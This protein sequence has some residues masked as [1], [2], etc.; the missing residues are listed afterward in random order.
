MKSAECNNPNH[1]HNRKEKRMNMITKALSPA[2]L[3]ALSLALT[4]WAAEPP[5]AQ[6]QD[7]NDTTGPAHMS[8]AVPVP[9][10]VPVQPGEH[11]RLLF[12]KTDLPAIKARAQTPEGKKIVER[13]KATLGGGEAM[14]TV[15]NKAKRAYDENSPAPEGAF[16]ITHMAGFGMLYQLTGDKKYAE[17]GRQCFLKGKEGIRDRD[18][19]YSQT[20]VDGQLRLGPSLAM[21]ALG[22]DLCYDG[23]DEAFRQEVAQFIQ[24]YNMESRSAKDGPKPPVLSFKG[25][26]SDPRH[27]PLSNHQGAALGGAGFAVL[28]LLGDPGTDTALLKEMDAK[29]RERLVSSVPEGFGPYAFYA[30]GQGPSHVGVNSGL[31]PYVQALRVAAGQDYV[32]GSS[33]VQWFTLRWVMEVLGDGQGN[34]LYPARYELMGKSYGKERMLLGNGG[35]THGG[36]FSQGFGTIPE[37]YKPAL[38]WTYN[39]FAAAEDQNRF[40]T[41]N[42]PHRAIMA[43]VNWPIGMKAENPAGVMPKAICDTLH[44]YYVIRNRWQDSDDVVITMFGKTGKYRQQKAWLKR[45]IKVFGVGHQ[46]E[47]SGITGQ[48]DHMETAPDGSTSLRWP[49]KAPA[50]FAVDFS[51]RGGVEAVI[52]HSLG[53]KEDSNT[54]RTLQRPVAIGGLKLNCLTLSTTDRHP[55]VTAGKVGDKPAAIIGGLAVTLEDG[56]LVFHDAPGAPAAMIEAKTLKTLF[57]PPVVDEKDVKLPTDPSYALDFDSRY[58]QDD[59]LY[60]RNMA[61][62]R[63]VNGKGDAMLRGVTIVPGVLGQG[64]QVGKGVAFVPAEATET[65]LG[66]EKGFTVSYWIYT[67]SPIGA[68]NFQI[69]RNGQFYSGYTKGGYRGLFN[70][71]CD[72]DTEVDPDQWHHVVW[73]GDPAQKRLSLWY[74]G[75]YRGSIPSSARLDSGPGTLGIGSHVANED[76]PSAGFPWQG[77]LDEIRLFRRPLTVGEAVALY[78]EGA[79]AVAEREAGGNQAPSAVAEATPVKGLP[80]LA[81]T[82]D[83][84]GSKDP[85]EGKLT[86]AWDFGD[87]TKGTGATS[88]H[89]YTK[90]GK[91]VAKLTVTDDKGS[92]VT[93]E[94]SIRVQNEAP[95]L[96]VRA[97]WDAAAARGEAPYG[98]EDIK[99]DASASVDP[100]GKPLKFTWT[101]AGQSYEGAVVRAKL[102]SPGAHPVALVADD[103]TGRTTTWRSM[104]NRPDAEGRS[105]AET[106]VGTYTPGLH[107]RYFHQGS[108]QMDLSLEKHVVFPIEWNVFKH[109]GTAHTPLP[110]N[111]RL[112]PVHYWI[113]WAGYLEVPADGEYTF[114]FNV[115][116]G[117]YLWLG[118]RLIGNWY[119]GFGSKRQDEFKDFSVKLQKGAHR[120]RLV[121]MA[122]K[123][124]G[125]QNL[126]LTWTGPGFANVFIPSSAFTRS[127]T[128][129]EQQAAGIANPRLGSDVWDWFPEPNPP[130]EAATPPP[131]T[132]GKLELTINGPGAD[133]YVTASVKL[134]ADFVEPVE[135]VYHPG[136]GSRVLA[137]EFGRVYPPGAEYTVTVE[138]TDAAGRSATV[139]RKISV[140]ATPAVESI[141]LVFVRRSAQEFLRPT[142]VAGVFPQ[143][144]WNS[145]GWAGEKIRDSAGREMALK[146]SKVEQ[147]L[148]PAMSVYTGKTG[149]MEDQ[150]LGMTGWFGTKEIALEGIPYDRYDLVVIAP[151]AKG[152]KGLQEMTVAVG[153]QTRT[154]KTTREPSDFDGRY[155]EET[156]ANPAGN[157]IVFR[158]LTGPNQ[159]ITFASVKGSK[160][161]A[162]NALQIIRVK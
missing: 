125:Q 49:G 150:L 130:M 121:F 40:D 34:A 73:I 62:D 50:L 102:P 54:Y 156:D 13:L 36:W 75:K 124:G 100:E 35:M 91:Y 143:G 27:G 88:T 104:V 110:W 126:A 116:G 117:A 58:E 64:I 159:T 135:V 132:K 1:G 71:Q 115:K 119:Q 29:C 113:D 55:A 17:L 149:S 94:K 65:D 134:P 133:R 86:Y 76:V 85:E 154:V 70:D 39:T 118:S 12:R 139:F 161:P 2:L 28:G 15:Y 66:G 7:K 162:I 140:P 38:L 84:S 151:G 42:Y 9:G 21:L 127:L 52:V 98:P 123:Y 99:L 106:P 47:L 109:F 20:H 129:A 53:M 137:R 157:Y 145:V 60:A 16:T 114:H 107:Y 92:A 5:K 48:H 61:S 120:F 8:W 3:I 147:L 128:V 146:V 72:V 111:S 69:H 136:D 96:E 10:F 56:K 32:S 131:A 101:V 57:V 31:Q 108:R 45:P 37:K 46:V 30:E 22:Y 79:N 25:L 51:R 105:L 138:A 41:L 155:I 160:R 158:G 24:N 6:P 43:L 148:H 83:G 33:M 74:D 141:G 122:N 78:R 153:G 26:V 82:F 103:G 14:P 59:V 112:R 90:L 11:P 80:P 23:W 19:R 68:S 93:I 152:E 18:N 89:T 77:R 81:V 63:R 87:G 44:G 142:T 97:G 4:A 95:R 67:D 144:Y